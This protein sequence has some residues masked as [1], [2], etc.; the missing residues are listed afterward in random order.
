MSRTL[1]MNCGSVDSFQV[2]SRCGLRPN[3]RQIREMADLAQ[4][5]GA[6]HRPGRPVGVVVGRRFPQRLGDHLL[7]LLV[8]DRARATWP[9]LID[10]PVQP[11]THEPTSPLGDRLRP[12]PQP[13][14][15]GL[16]G[17]AFRARQ[18]DPAA[19]RQRLGGGGPT[20]PAHQRLA[21]LVGQHQRRFGSA[22]LSHARQPT[23]IIQRINN[24][25]H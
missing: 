25:G 12:D 16:V 15:P 18:H 6:G 23:T 14:G 17:R 2:C 3:A 19:Q 13:L 24:S 7:H 5:G 4:P 22:S 8:G 9:R 10:Q 11:A 21:L 1:S 20:R